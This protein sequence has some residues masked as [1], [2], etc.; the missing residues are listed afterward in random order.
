MDSEE[1]RTI[2][3][4]ALKISIGVMHKSKDEL[5]VLY[6]ETSGLIAGLDPDKVETS[7]ANYKAG[8]A[9]A[10]YAVITALKELEKL[11]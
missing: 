6:G 11:S 10:L 7:S 4:I 9:Q 3:L 1:I 8:A 2:R 5:S